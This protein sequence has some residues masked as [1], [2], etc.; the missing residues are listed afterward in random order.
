MKLLIKNVIQKINE[1]FL[2]YVSLRHFHLFNFGLRTIS[3]PNFESLNSNARI[4]GGVDKRSTA[5]SKMYRLLKNESVRNIFIKI[6]KGLNLL[7]P[8]SFVNIDFSTFTLGW[9]HPRVS[10]FKQ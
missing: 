7:T 9:K 8:K 5:E 3:L 2:P 1:Y 4:W 10:H 6:L